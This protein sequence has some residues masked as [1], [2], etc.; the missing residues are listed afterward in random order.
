MQ[1]EDGLLLTITNCWGWS[2][3]NAEVRCGRFCAS[4]QMVCLWSIADRLL[5]DLLPMLV[6]AEDSLPWACRKGA[7]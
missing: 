1:M 2:V 5:V 6:F 7:K 3:S 4:I